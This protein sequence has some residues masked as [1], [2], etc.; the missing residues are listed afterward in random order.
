MGQLHSYK[1]ELRSLPL[2]IQQF[3][4]VVDDAFFSQREG[5]EI[6][7]GNVDVKLEV[8]H[9]N[10]YFDLTFMVKGTIVVG[11]DRCLDDMQ[12]PVDTDYQVTLKYAEESNIDDDE[13]IEV[14]E[15]E[16]DYDLTDLIYDT[17]ALT[18]PMK[19][20]HAEG[21]CNAAMVAE[22]DKHS[23]AADGERE[24]TNDPRWE[25]LRGLIDNNK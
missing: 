18:V 12:L 25:A 8:D 16:R 24:E 14:S 5:S 17:I 22:L 15:R 6:R 19:H 9:R 10:D 20:T 7:G 1:L 3:N 13:L 23:G 11:C 21:Q 2:G 4:Y